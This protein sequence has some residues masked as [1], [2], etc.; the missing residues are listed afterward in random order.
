MKHAL[1]LQ[2]IYELLQFVK[3]LYEK[4][5]RKKRDDEAD[6]IKEDAI[7]AWGDLFGTTADRLPSNDEQ[8]S[9]DD[10]M[11]ADDAKATAGEPNDTGCRIR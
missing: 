8:T 11:P 2:L 1:V 9:A 5:E 4:H 3:R 7:S 6:A 10:S